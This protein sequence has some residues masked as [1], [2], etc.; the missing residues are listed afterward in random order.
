MSDH[1]TSLIQRL[2][3]ERDALLKQKAALQTQLAQLQQSAA[4]KEAQIAQLEAKQQQQQQQ[5]ALVS[6]TVT[7]TAAADAADETVTSKAAA[8]AA[9]RKVDVALEQYQQTLASTDGDAS[10]AGSNLLFFLMQ[11]TAHSNG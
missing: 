11:A 7:S 3:N 10:A 9:E 1:E 4:A 5:P 6:T 2:E 8:D